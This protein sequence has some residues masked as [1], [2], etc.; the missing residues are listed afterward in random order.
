[1][2]SS[3]QHPD[4]ITLLEDI[5]DEVRATSAN[6]HLT[7]KGTSFF[8]GQ[9]A[10]KK[11]KEVQQLVTALLNAGVPEDDISVRSVSLSVEKGMIT[12]S[13][14]ARYAL[15]VHVR[16]LEK[17]PDVLGAITGSNTVTMDTI[18]WRYDDLEAKEDAWMLEAI[19]KANERAGKIADGLKVKITGVHDFRIRK[20]GEAAPYAN[21][22]DT[23]DSYE[24][25]PMKRRAVV[26]LG[27]P[28]VQSMERGIAVTI[29]YRIERIG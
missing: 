25:A 29:E 4:R 14:S 5:T 10:I 23:F 27:T 8:S 28:M 15:K 3:D 17:L 7:V 18:E 13:S 19:R 16:D 26:D 2:P 1:M 22:N 9:A 6:L 11:A 24:S 12:K 21:Y 20:I